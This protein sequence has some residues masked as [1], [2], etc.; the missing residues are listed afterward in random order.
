[1]ETFYQHVEFL[2]TFFV[3]NFDVYNMDAP[4]FVML[5]MSSYP[6][7]PSHTASLLVTLLTKN[8]AFVVLDS[9]EFID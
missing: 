8:N 9:M 5:L 7:A 2:Q 6:F 1:M 4:I 3:W